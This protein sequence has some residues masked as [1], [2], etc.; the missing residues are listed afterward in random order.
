MSQQ[1]IW[2]H[3]VRFEHKGVP[4]F[5][6]VVNPKADGDLDEQFE[7]EIATGDPVFNNIKLTG[8]K[9]TVIRN[10]L[11][12]P[13]ATV[14]MV[15]NTGLN[16]KDHVQ[17]SLFYSAPDLFPN[18]PYIFYRPATSL[19]PPYPALLRTYKV[20]QECLDYEGEMVFQ[21]GSRPLKDISVEE[22]AKNI[23]GFTTGCDFSPRPGKILGR[24]N[25]IF[26]KAFDNWTP[27][28]PVLVHPSVVGNPPKLE[29]TTK[30]NGEVV[31]HDNTENMIFTVA[32]ILSSMSIGTTVQPGT[33]VFSGTCGGG[34]WFKSEG[35]AG[36]GIKDGDEIE[37]EVNGLGKV[38]AYPCFDK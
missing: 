8:E 15:V 37:V 10:K 33:V 7:V 4:T 13:F 28:G 16:Y 24:M 21:T 36:T 35:A 18:M 3:L 31:Q 6:Q 32:Q 11:L 1:S 27:A 26:S 29:L 25:F 19:A 9:A 17:E 20:Q 12:A 2:T 23:V 5:A 38:R 22:A 34:T 30:W 14:P